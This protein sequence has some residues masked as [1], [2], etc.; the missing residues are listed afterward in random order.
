MTQASAVRQRW[1]ATGQDTAHHCRRALGWLTDRE[2]LLFLALIVVHLIPVWG[3]QHFPSQDGP[4]HLENAVIVREY[5]DPERTAFRTFYELNDR[6]TPNWLGHLVLAGLMTLV[7]PLVAEKVFLS[8]YLILLPLAIRYAVLG[9]RRDSAFLAVLGFPFVYNYTLHMGFYSFSYSLAMFFLVIGYWLRHRE[10]AGLRHTVTLAVLLL[11]LY[12]AHIVSAVT[13]GLAIG[14][15]TLWQMLPELARQMRERQFSWPRLR[16]ALPT[17]TPLY[18]AVPTLALFGLF[19]VVNREQSHISWE[20]KSPL[21]TLMKDLL[22]L[23]SLV[24]YDRQEVW[25]A[26]AVAGLF[27]SIV[28][29]LILS[30]RVTPRFTFW[31]GFVLL[32]VLYGLIYL[33]GPSSVGGGSYIHDRMNLYPALALIIWFAAHTYAPAARRSIQGLGV[34]LAAVLLGLHSVKYRE[35]NDY[36]AEYLSASPHI[37]PNTTVLPITFSQGGAAPGQPPLSWRIDVFLNAAGYIA[38]ERHVVELWNYE[39]SQTRFFPIVFRPGLNPTAYLQYAPLDAAS[40]D[41]RA[42]PTGLVAFSQRTGREI[43]YVVVWG[44]REPDR[45]KDTPRLIF[46]QLEQGFDLIY[47]SPQRGLMQLY[48]RKDFEHAS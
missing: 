23:H 19:M 39:A 17:L 33:V 1:P 42:L 30:R 9:V 2:N 32:S 14:L 46:G 24:S 25:V 43:D 31:D 10:S 16:S 47:T 37:E 7:P 44:V 12:F 40:G 22:S 11:L 21:T 5:Q 8:G 38:A 35:L 45:Q 36:L 27:G 20:D 18:A 41:F 4:A 48:R 26:R 3:Y 15:L 6:F 29:Y 34:A 13:A 28:L